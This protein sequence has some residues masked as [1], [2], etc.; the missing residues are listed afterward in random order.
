MVTPGRSCCA[1]RGAGSQARSAPSGET[2][3]APQVTLIRG[4][5]GIAED[6]ITCC[7]TRRSPACAVRSPRRHG[8]H[9]KAVESSHDPESGKPRPGQNASLAGGSLIGF[10]ETRHRPG[11]ATIK[12]DGSSNVGETREIASVSIE[13]V[14]LCA[15]TSPGGT[16]PNSRCARRPKGGAHSSSLSFRPAPPG[17]QVAGTSTSCLC[18][19]RGSLCRS[20]TRA[21]LAAQVTA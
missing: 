19:A 14:V 21:C 9:E 2:C 3:R 1:K 18:T 5:C 13:Y 4:Q 17:L 15:A 11:D 8:P 16:Q 7:R 20:A 10:P 6:S 12:T